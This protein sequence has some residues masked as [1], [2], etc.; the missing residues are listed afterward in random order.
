MRIA[1]T[2]GVLVILM[3]ISDMRVNGQDFDENLDLENFDNSMLDIFDMIE[4][5]SY[6]FPEE[7]DDTFI[8]DAL[9]Y[10][11]DKKSFIKWE[12]TEPV[13]WL[14]INNWKI[15]RA[16]KDKVPHWQ[17]AQRELGIVETVGRVLECVGR[18]RV[19]RG[20]G[21]ANAQ[22]RSRIEEGDEVHTLKDSYLWVYL[23][24]GTL[25]RFA[26]DTT[27]T[28]KEINISLDRFFYHLRLNSGN[29]VWLDRR[30]EKYTPKIERESDPIFYPLTLYNANG[31]KEKVKV[32][33]NNLFEF[34]R[35]RKTH[36]NK[37]VR[38]NN[39]IDENNF[40]LKKKNT[41]VFFTM[42][43]GTLLGNDPNFEAI[44]L[45]GGKSYV[46]VL[47]SEKLGLEKDQDK[48]DLKLF[49]RGYQ[50]REEKALSKNTWFE[51]DKKGR[52]V[53]E[54]DEESEKKF[55][56]G[57][58]LVSKIPTILIGRELLLKKYSLQYFNTR[59]TPKLLARWHYRL[60]DHKSNSEDEI[61]RR[62]EFLKEYTRREETS[63]LLASKQ[64]IKRLK[65]KGETT[66]S[67][68]YDSSYYGLAMD[69]YMK[70]GEIKDDVST[71]RSILNSTKKI[72]WK[73]INAAK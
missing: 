8:G 6:A 47:D 62:I 33:E 48:T 52:N 36:F 51:I 25:I 73:Y 5:D 63:S 2:I 21:Y 13:E 26:P 45:L 67:V 38:L 12:D 68:I 61:D 69:A 3:V 39:L 72:F 16:I 11:G 65:A 27:V 19:Y 30:R 15:E 57:Q 59:L 53:T 9:H 55:G 70:Y 60:W 42:P 4:D 71:D 44:V 46:K 23:Y 32:N 31:A 56:F 17:I 50:N 37:Y 34:L 35:P 29:V 7:E 24:D 10:I 41:T 54:L 22:Y 66:S 43:N 18:C 20:E 58:F 40:V 28:F 49:F 1:I 64:F 14:D